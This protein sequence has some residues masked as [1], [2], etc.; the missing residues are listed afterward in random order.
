MR[1]LVVRTRFLAAYVCN[2]H[3]ASLSSCSAVNLARDLDVGLRIRLVGSEARSHASELRPSDR[4][5][6]C[7]PSA[8]PCPI[9]RSTSR[10]CYIMGWELGDW[11]HSGLVADGAETLS[12]VLSPP[13]QPHRRLG[14]SLQDSLQLLQPVPDSGGGRTFFTRH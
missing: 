6:P 12:G 4:H 8:L 13:K 9:S 7:R 11:P 1:F 10:P 5:L 14:S 2:K 3:S